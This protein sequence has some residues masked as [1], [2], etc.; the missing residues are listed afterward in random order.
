MTQQ[1]DRWRDPIGDWLA[2]GRPMQHATR[3][4]MLSFSLFT[5]ACTA[6][7]GPSW[8]TVPS[9]MAGTIGVLG[10]LRAYHMRWCVQMM[11]RRDKL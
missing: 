7:N 4:V 6:V 11:L 8:T 9:V 5:I 2:G 3:F 1:T 10:A